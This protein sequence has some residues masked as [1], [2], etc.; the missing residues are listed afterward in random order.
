MG[1]SSSKIHTKYKFDKKNFDKKMTIIQDSID[2]THFYINELS[3]GVMPMTLSRYYNY[4]SV[5]EEYFNNKR[6]DTIIELLNQNAKVRNLYDFYIQLTL[7]QS[8][9][10]NGNMTNDDKRNEIKLI[11]DTSISIT[12][13]LISE[14]TDDDLYLD[15]K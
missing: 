13:M 2:L 7:L 3:N 4:N 1:N 5:T 6:K 12:K 8:R 10:E 11:V 15:K 14:L 9:Y